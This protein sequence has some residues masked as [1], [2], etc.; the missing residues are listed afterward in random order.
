MKSTAR[1]LAT[2]LAALAWILAPACVRTESARKPVATVNLVIARSA[3]GT[4]LS[5][6]SVLGQTYTVQM[7]DKSKPGAKWEFHPQGINL[8]GTGSDM[9][10]VDTPPPGM[11]RQY[12]LHLFAVKGSAVGGAR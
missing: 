4:T 9:R 11:T 7:R 1:S 12:R 6:P 3:Q 8:S 2:A 5:W 10:F